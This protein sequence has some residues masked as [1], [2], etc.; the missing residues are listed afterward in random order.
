MKIAVVSFGSI[1]NTQL[2]E[3]E[4]YYKLLISKTFKIEYIELKDISERKVVLGDIPNLK[5]KNLFLS[6][7]GKEFTTNQFADQ[8]NLWMNQ[9]QDVNFIIANAFGFDDN[10]KSTQLLFSLSKMTF[11]HEFAKIILLEQIFRVGDLLKGGKYHK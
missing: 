4:G 7:D 9:S 11:P 3:L 2:K 5:G 8:L 10:I 1:K 6:E